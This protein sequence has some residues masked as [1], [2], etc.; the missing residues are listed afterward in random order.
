MTCSL[1]F[2]PLLAFEYTTTAMAL[3]AHWAI[4]NNSL[5]LGPLCLTLRA[6]VVFLLMS[7]LV[8]LFYLLGQAVDSVFDGIYGGM[9][10]NVIIVFTDWPLHS[11]ANLRP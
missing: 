5:K 9:E 8:E 2:L 4:F 11:V 1:P 10:V 3:E 6:I 7:R